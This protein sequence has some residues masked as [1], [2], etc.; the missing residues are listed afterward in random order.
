MARPPGYAG[1]QPTN[2]AGA[3]RRVKGLAVAAVI[4]TAVAGIGQIVSI[5]T[6]DAAREAAQ[7]YLDG[8]IDDDKLNERLVTSGAGSLIV[9][10]ATLALAVITIVWLHRIVSNH[11]NLGRRLTWSPGWAI[12]SWFLPP[13]FLFVLPFLVIRESFKASDPTSPPG[14]E[15]WRNSGEHPLPWIWVLTYGIAPLVLG[16]ISSFA[17]FNGFTS[18]DADDVAERILDT[19]NWVTYAQGGLGIVA[20]IAW[21]LLVWTLTQRHMQLTGEATAR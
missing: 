7:D 8:V 21:A 9:G 12:A 1:Y 11:Q 19:D 17:F 14:T 4:L 3:L 13:C 2:W 18:R 16:I 10:A 15:T 5:A 20:A 6:A